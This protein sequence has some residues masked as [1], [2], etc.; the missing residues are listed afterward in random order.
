MF[1]YKPSKRK[2]KTTDY[3]YS[4]VKTAIQLI[5]HFLFEGASPSNSEGHKRNAE[6]RS[7]PCGFENRCRE[8]RA[9][10][11]E[12]SGVICP[13]PAYAECRYAFLTAANPSVACGDTSPDRGGY[14]TAYAVNSAGS[15]PAV[16][17]YNKMRKS[18]RLPAFMISY[19][20]LNPLWLPIRDNSG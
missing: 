14:V 5:K 19:R 18:R 6:S 9:A 13:Q 15:A 3:N 11:V 1:S 16:K 2:H 20:A 8:C 12:I 17:D 10:L 4:T 7:L